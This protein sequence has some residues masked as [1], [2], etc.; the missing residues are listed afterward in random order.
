MDNGVDERDAHV[1]AEGLKRG[2]TLVTAKVPDALVVA[3]EAIFLKHGV[4]IAARRDDYHAEGWSRFDDKASA[5]GVIR[6]SDAR[7]GDGS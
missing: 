6:R 7:S 1:F 4:D 2:G 3:A 5:P